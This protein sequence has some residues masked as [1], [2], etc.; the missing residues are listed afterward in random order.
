[1]EGLTPMRIALFIPCYI[2]QLFPHVGIAT[3]RLLQQQGLTAEVLER[4]LCC[5]QPYTNAGAT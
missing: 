4:Q 3:L 5:G 2:D 1:M